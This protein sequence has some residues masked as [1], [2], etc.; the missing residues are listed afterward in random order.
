MAYTPASNLTSSAGLAHLQTVLYRKK[1]LSRLMK[2]FVFRSACQKDT[3]SKNSGRTVQW[4][5]YNNLSADT[6]PAAEGTVGT[7]QALSSRVYQATVSQYANFVTVSDLLEATALDAIVINASELLGYQAGLTV[8]TMCRNIIDSESVNTAQTPLAT[9]ARVNDFRNARHSLQAVDVE[10]FESG[11]FK[12]F[13]HPYASYDL[14]ADPAASGL[15]D[16]FKYN[17]NP[18]S[19]ALVKYEDRGHIADVAG[20]EII[21][22]TNTY[23]GTSGSNNT[24]RAYVFGMGGVGTV[25]LEGNAP[26]DIN[27]PQKQRFSIKTIRNTGNIADPEGL[28]GAAVSYN[29]VTTTVI[30]DT[31]T[32]RY[33][34]IDFQSSIA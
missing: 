15:A 3:L 26:S 31:S 21:E 2:K 25:D 6:T 16:I 33:K 5:R 24:Y 17:T 28:I 18:N 27:D 9:V 14:V 23:T 8:D 1:G 4:F 13:I 30:L 11:K 29:F 32:Y 12:A 20:C 34:T 19:S 10:P 7:G 22:T